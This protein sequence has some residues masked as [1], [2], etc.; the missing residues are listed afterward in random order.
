M[1]G[2]CAKRGHRVAERPEQQ[3]V[4][5]RVR[6]VVL[7]A[8]DVGDLHRRVVDDDREVIQRAAVAADDDEVAAQ[9]GDVDLD[10]TADDVVEG[11]DA[12]PDPESKRAR[13]AVGDPRRPLLGGQR[14]AP[15]DVLRRQLGRLLGGPVGGELLGRAV[16]GIGQVDGQQP[17][18]RR[19]IR[20][21]PLHLAIRRVR[22][23]GGLAGDLRALVPAQAEPVQAVEDVLLELDRAASL[24]RVLE[25]E[26]ERAARVPG[27]QVVEQ[28]R[29]GGPDVEW[30]G[31]ARGDP[32][33][34]DGQSGQRAGTTWNSARVGDA[35]QDAHERRG[36][37]AQRRA[38]PRALERQRVE[39]ARIGQDPDVR[40]R[41]Q[42]PG[43]QVRQQPGVLLG[44]LGDAVDRR[45]RAGLDLAQADPGRPLARRLGVDRVAVRAGHRMTEHLVEPGLDPR[46]DGALESHRLVVRFGP[47]EPDD[48]GQQPLEQGVPSED[49]V[50]GGPAR[51]R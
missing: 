17:L 3:D 29:P 15:S 20:R 49:A 36:P 28:R 11:D 14:R 10:V 35:R 9:V 24:V 21:Q 5:R 13:P 7:A 2:R 32:D 27:V 1:S 22:S 4:L 23:A 8:D 42:R 48:G 12:G 45:I 51:R 33:A 50:G 18:G 46:R 34:R 38:A 25:A 19:G 41:G 31:G 43:L 39:R 16:A 37:Q 40:A 47:A 6:E 30:A 44:L 26:D